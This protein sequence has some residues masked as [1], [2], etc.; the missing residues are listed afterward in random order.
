MT[1]PVFDSLDQVPEPFRPFAREADGK[2]ALDLVPGAE[3]AG[4]RRKRDELLAELKATR[5][6]YDGVDPDDY[7]TIKAG[8]S[9]DVDARLDAA[10]REKAELQAQ[11][12]ALKVARRTDAKKAEIARALAEAGATVELLEPIVER[13]TDVEE[14]DGRM[15]VVVRDAQG[16]IRYRDGAGNRFGL[17]DLLAEM[18]GKDAYKPAFNVSVGSGGGSVPSSGG[19]AGVRVIDPSD[20]QAVMKAVQA[21][22]FTAGR[23][24]LAS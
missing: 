9:K 2:V 3:V 8:K 10:A 7:R 23:V 15:H 16:A 22:D 12:E 6:R 19:A 4:L 5:D 11:L 24:R 17:S 1:L 21:G 18:K 20:K 14:V 13:M